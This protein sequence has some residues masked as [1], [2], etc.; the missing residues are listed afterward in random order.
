MFP[1]WKYKGEK[2][3]LLEVETRL[4]GLELKQGYLREQI[5]E[6][7]KKYNM[8]MNDL[9]VELA[10]TTT[11]LNKVK[12][13]QDKLLFCACGNNKLEDEIVCKECI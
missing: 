1:L 11:S 8:Q 6:L 5:K 10:T 9:V 2:M 12:T 3:S 13:E 7:R 4:K